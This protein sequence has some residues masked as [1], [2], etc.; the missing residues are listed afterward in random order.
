MLRANSGFGGSV[1]KEDDW[2]LEYAQRVASHVK[3]R[4]RE[5]GRMAYLN[6]GRRTC[7]AHLGERQGAGSKQSGWSNAVEV[8]SCQALASGGGHP[9]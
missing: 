5:A 6:A 2:A 9:C 4:E 8:A 7:G 1:V 3:I